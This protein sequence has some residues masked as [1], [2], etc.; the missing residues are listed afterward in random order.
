[1][2]DLHSDFESYKITNGP[3]INHFYEIMLLLKNRLN[4]CTAIEIEKKRHTF[5]EVFLKQFYAE[6][7]GNA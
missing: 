2:P 1:M 3:T 6:W 5:M 4:T 7:E